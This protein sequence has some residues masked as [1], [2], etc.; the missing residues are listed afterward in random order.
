M[1]YTTMFTRILSFLLLVLAYFGIFM[2]NF[3]IQQNFHKCNV[4]FMKNVL[5]IMV[6]EQN[7]K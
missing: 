6:D 2:S 1:S 5:V 3:L 7:I 4:L